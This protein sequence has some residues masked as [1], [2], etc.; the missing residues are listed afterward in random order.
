MCDN[1][2]KSKTHPI[3]LSLGN[4]P[5]VVR[6]RSDSKALVGYLPIAESSILNRESKLTSVECLHK[7]MEVLLKPMME[8][9]HNGV[10]IIVN[11]QLQEATML[12]STIVADWLEAADYC[13]TAKAFNA[14]NHVILVLFPL[15]NSLQF[16]YKIQM[17]YY[18]HLNR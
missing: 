14:L 9:Y 10:S 13:A 17:Q 11:G 6:N 7:S 12:I 15:A 2:G 5:T 16:L 3:Y 4:L 18:E 8:Q 1:K